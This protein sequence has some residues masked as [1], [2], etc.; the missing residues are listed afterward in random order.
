MLVG[1]TQTFPDGVYYD[2]YRIGGTSLSAPLMAGMEA[3]AD[4]AAGHPHGFANPAIY[5]LRA[6]AVRDVVDPAQTLS[7]VRVDFVNGTDRAD[8]RTTSLRTF[9]QTQSIFTRP[10]YDDVTGVGSPIASV[11]VN[12]LGKK[13][14]ASD[15]VS[16]VVRRPG[17]CVR[18]W[19]SR[20]WRSLSNSGALSA[21]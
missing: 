19:N 2:Q 8:G 1:Q 10:G 14:G 4:Q 21:A 20:S 13:G 11:Y 18:A 12:A 15:R 5:R 9:N 16:R 6:Q 17:Q 3:L 7:A